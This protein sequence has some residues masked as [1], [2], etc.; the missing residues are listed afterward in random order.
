MRMFL[1]RLSAARYPLSGHSRTADASRRR[2]LFCLLSAASKKKP[3]STQST[4]RRKYFSRRS[5]RPSRFFP[6]VIPVQGTPHNGGAR[7]AL[8]GNWFSRRS[9]RPPRFFP[10]VQLRRFQTVPDRR[11]EAPLVVAAGRPVAARLECVGGVAHDV[12]RTG[13]IEHFDVV[14]V[15]ADR[16]DVLG[17][18]PAAFHPPR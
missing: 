3:R 12:G 9:P 4:Q 7:K 13:E 5:P 6:I 18:P 11:G 8:R 17:H 10:V 14:E 16:G 2:L 15:V 1:G